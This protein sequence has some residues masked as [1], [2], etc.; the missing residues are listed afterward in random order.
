[1]SDYVM[2]QGKFK[3]ILFRNEE[4]FYTVAK[5][6]DE[7]ENDTLTITGYFSSI[8]EEVSYALKGT[9]LDHP[10]YGL[11]FA[12]LEAKKIAPKDEE[13]Y[14][15]YFSGGNFRYIGK[16]TAKRIVETLGLDCI[17]KIKED[18]SCLDLVPSLTLKQKNSIIENLQQE[19][20]GFEKLIPLLSI[21]GIGHANLLSIHRFY[22][23][24]A[25][26]QVMENPYRLVEDIQGIG[27]KM[28]DKIGQYLNIDK[29]DER[30][31]YAYIL[32][33]VDKMTMNSGNSFV[34]YEELLA[35]FMNLSHLDETI[36]S[37]VLNQILFRGSLI[38]EE[39]RIYPLAQYEAEVGIANAL[40]QFPVGSLE[41]YDKQRLEKEIHALQ[42][43]LGIIYDE[44]QIQAIHHFFQE[45]FVILTGGPG[46]G[47]TTLVR[48][49][50]HL[51]KRL[52][53]AKVVACCA[54]TGRAAKH[55]SEVCDVKATTIHSLLQWNLEANLFQKNEE[56]PIQA[57]LLIIDEFSMVD[58]WLFY[59]ILLA[60]GLVKKI[61][62]IGD[63]DQLPSV[64]PGS[65][66]R[67]LIVSK[68]FGYRQLTHIY[69]QKEGSEVIQLAL[70]IRQESLDLT[71][72]HQDVQ[73]EECAIHEIRPKI[74]AVIQ[75][76]L[77]KG[78]TLEDIQVIAPMYHGTAGIDALNMSLQDLFNPAKENK[79]EVQQGL[80]L[81]REGDKVMQLKNQPDDDV[82][83]G[84]IGF[85]EEIQI[86][87][88][89]HPEQALIFVLFGDHVVEY[90]HQNLDKLSLAYCISIHKSQGS[91]YPMV[92]VPICAQHRIMLRKRLLYTAVTRSSKYLYIFGSRE[93]F[94]RGSYLE[95]KNVRK[96]TLVQRLTQ[97]N[98]FLW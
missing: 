36:F 22:G 63:E 76:A 3:Y 14:I 15:H 96:T 70:A 47:K 87:D 89:K 81:F 78:L 11:Q 38:Q 62:V 45:D 73:F 57:D 39:N 95:E 29:K 93:E 50:V 41:D 84:D 30:R 43:E 86:D 33:L 16:K 59:H 75:V 83:N 23:K 65:L 2:L 24:E 77:E 85:I 6:H 8:D 64:A 19:E 97:Q 94:E 12:C 69:R 34:S 31:I 49:F 32:S 60:C 37:S 10:K 88:P 55:L 56:D 53:P 71:K 17:A 40:S 13:S 21:A 80:R 1:M 28:A 35:N 54:P 51:F 5:F 25:F 4:N 42:K 98:S 9:Y 7:I 52:Y 79:K 68:Q 72:F 91:E 20:E 82:Y 61:C 26:N 66:L 74:Q 92:I 90:S 18:K 67:D 27:F 44:T 58:Q 46:T 48:S